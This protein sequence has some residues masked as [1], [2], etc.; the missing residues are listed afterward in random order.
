MA[1]VTSQTILR[2][3]FL[4]GTK[5]GPKQRT[6]TA[7]TA[8]TKIEPLGVE[9]GKRMT[10]GRRNE[11]FRI[12]GEE[13][14]KMDMTE[15]S[16]GPTSRRDSMH[17]HVSAIDTRFETCAFLREREELFLPST[18]L[19]LEAMMFRQFFVPSY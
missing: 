2:C 13:E 14:K 3:D 18:M 12:V 1:S 19:A 9:K 6:R 16:L 4:K 10:V 5:L 11:R 8:F 17:V 15:V 7:D